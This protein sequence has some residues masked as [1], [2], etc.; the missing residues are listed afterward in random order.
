MYAATDAVT[1][2]GEVYQSLRVISRR[3]GGPAVVAWE[4][5]RELVLLDLTTNWPVL[6][7]ASAALMMGEKTHTQTWARAIDFRLGRDFDGLYSLSSITGKP[8]VTLF[9]RTERVPA[10]PARPRFHAMLTDPAADYL[11][12]LAVDDLGYDVL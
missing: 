9:S 6:N 8:M 2:F 12:Q 7:G 5:S 11:V 3:E 1:P 10:F 4:P